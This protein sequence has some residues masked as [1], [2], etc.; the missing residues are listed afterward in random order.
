MSRCISCDAKLTEYELTIKYAESGAYVDLCSCCLKPIRSQIEIITREDLNNM[1]S[2][3]D[4]SDEV[5]YG[6]DDS[7]EEREDEF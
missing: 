6:Y 5:F 2:L 3:E 4:E 7:D 1:I